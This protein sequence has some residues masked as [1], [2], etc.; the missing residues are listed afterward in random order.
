MIVL[1]PY[2]DFKTFQVFSSLKAMLILICSHKDFKTFQVFSSFFYICNIH[3]CPTNF[4]TFQ[5]YSSWS[6][7]TYV[8]VIAVA[9]QNFSSL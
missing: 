8:D 7:E 5:V 4:K 9:F 3:S 1:S 6:G 2:A